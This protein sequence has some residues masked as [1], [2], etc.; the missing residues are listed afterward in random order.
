MK[1]RNYISKK[2]FGRKIFSF[3]VEVEASE[4]EVLET[5]ES[6]VGN[7]LT[8]FCQDYRV[9]GLMRDEL[10][11]SDLVFPLEIT[12]S[13]VGVGRAKSTERDAVEV[14]SLAIERTREGRFHRFVGT[15][16]KKV[17]STCCA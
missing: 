8:R 15:L 14:H 7:W 16:N 13:H 5:I 4:E 10:Y 1:Y 11:S 2:D 17:E 12:I 9:Y 6:E 3:L